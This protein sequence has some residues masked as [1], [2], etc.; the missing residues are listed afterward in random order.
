MVR[1]FHWLVAG[2]LL[3][4]PAAFGQPAPAPGAVDDDHVHPPAPAGSQSVNQYTV[5]PGTAELEATLLAPCCWNQTLDNHN[6][7]VANEV[8]REIRV[9][10]LAGEDVDTV[11]AAMARK[12]GE[13]IVAVPDDSPL[14]TVALGLGIAVGVAGLI[15]AW[16][17]I[18]WRRK[19]EEAEAA[20]RGARAENEKANESAAEPDEFDERLDQELEDDRDEYDR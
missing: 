3:V 8:R 18:R 20:E 1:G 2:F 16:A 9:R 12:Y 10:L 5:V 13:R 14:A 11:R 19:S 17:L 7:D 15:A 4:S 6:S